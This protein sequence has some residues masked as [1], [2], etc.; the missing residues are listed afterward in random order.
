LGSLGRMGAWAGP[1]WA[2]G[3]L[4]WAAAGPGEGEVDIIVFHVVWYGVLTKE[5]SSMLD[6]QE[7]ERSGE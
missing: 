5:V 6:T 1:G 4:V 7:N 3:G 2:A